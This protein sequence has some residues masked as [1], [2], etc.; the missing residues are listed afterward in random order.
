MP[1]LMV[2]PFHADEAPSGSL[3]LADDCPAVH[4]GMYDVHPRAP[5]QHDAVSTM[6]GVGARI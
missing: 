5:G 2:A 1:K 3:K 6:V 4:A